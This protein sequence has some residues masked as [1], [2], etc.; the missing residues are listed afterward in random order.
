MDKNKNSKKFFLNKN[1]KLIFFGGKGGAGK[2]TCAAAAALHVA[3][4]NPDKK[5]LVFSTDPAHSLSDSFDQ[6]IGDKE[7]L[8]KG[9]KANNL[10]ALEINTKKLLEDERQ[11][12][13]PRIDKQ[14][15]ES[16]QITLE[17]EFM[18]RAW[19][20]IPPGFDELMSLLKLNDL[21]EDKEYDIIV[22]DTAA[23]AHTIRLL[24]LPEKQG[25]WLDR[26]LELFSRWS[27]IPAGVS[28]KI[29]KRHIAP[30]IEIRDKFKTLDEGLKKLRALFRDSTKSNFILITIPEKMGIDVTT[31]M[32]DSLKHCGIAY[33]TIIV[34]YIIS[35][36]KCDFCAS[37][38]KFQTQH[39][40]EIHDKFSDCSIIEL[41]LFP[42]A[43]RGKDLSD[44]SKVLFGGKHS[45]KNF[46]VKIQGAYKRTQ[47]L[48]LP[49]D[50]RFLLFGGKG[51]VGKTTSSAATGIYMA[52]DKK[53][54]VISTDPQRYLSDSFDQKLPESNIAK[55]NEINNLYALE[56][57][58]E[59]AM[60]EFKKSHEEEIMQ[61]VAK[62]IDV[63]DFLDFVP[64][65]DEIM[66]LM[67][68]AD[69]LVEEKY[70]LLILDTAPTGHTL[71]FMELPD[72]FSKWTQLL[73]E[74][75]IKTRHLMYLY[76][77]NVKYKIDLFLEKLI[78]DAK[79]V[80]S[81]LKDLTTN[82]IPVT[83]LDEM[84]I[85]ETE[86][87]IKSLQS[88]QINVK[89]IIVNGLVSPNKCSYCAS[90]F[91]LQQK[92]FQKLRERFRDFEIISMQ[93]F[94]Y[95]IYGIDKLKKFAN[96]LFG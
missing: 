43:V 57:D 65:M 16:H 52:S 26:A 17:R 53:V 40:R 20:L 55:V 2:T 88:Y 23:G 94:P 79:Q 46:K 30:I 73:M 80:K 32:M 45:I 71:A 86:H 75:R 24:E 39:I 54:L 91:N 70:E 82:F 72:I 42:K 49:K 33:D 50:I 8:I 58:T 18:K 76:K 47:R 31:D 22:V 81:I 96:A 61:L 15:R 48:K 62:D 41:P 14:L 6:Q 69:L 89:Q 64:G 95:E 87:L 59:K 63:K 84:A 13:K 19:D 25:W 85:N 28:P 9:I 5:I 7:T 90:A 4:S 27:R 92:N 66:A 60:N 44:F 51:G 83:T 56:I 12:Y 77:R 93:L 10:Y 36:T 34:N 29:A 74:I 78:R 68:I 1:L 37:R 35:S 11:W 38:R 3:S 21:V 67:R